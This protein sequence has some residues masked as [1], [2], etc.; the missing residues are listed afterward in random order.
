MMLGLYNCAVHARVCIKT[1]HLN[2][3]VNLRMSYGINSAA[4]YQDME[5]CDNLTTKTRNMLVCTESYLAVQ[6]RNAKCD[7]FDPLEL[8]Y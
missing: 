1:I 3:Q 6:N 2:Q 5:R 8:N 7:F 4:G